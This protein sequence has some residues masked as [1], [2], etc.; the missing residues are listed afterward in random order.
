MYL[1]IDKT[2]HHYIKKPIQRQHTFS[3]KVRSKNENLSK[4]KKFKKNIFK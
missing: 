4:K 2:V 1:N 3:P